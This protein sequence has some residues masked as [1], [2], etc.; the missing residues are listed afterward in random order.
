MIIDRYHP[1]QCQQNQHIDLRHH[2]HHYHQ[3]PDH[4]H[5]HHPHH[6]LNISIRVGMTFDDTNDGGLYVFH[7]NATHPMVRK[8][9]SVAINN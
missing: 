6:Y 1:C 7:Q 3:L 2:H 4:P 9:K 5:T 8:S